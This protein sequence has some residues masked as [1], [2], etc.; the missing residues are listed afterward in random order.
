M[1]SL[2]AGLMVTVLAVSTG[3]N[4][5]TPGGPGATERSANKPMVERADDT[6]ILDVPMTSTKL[7]QGETKELA[8]SVARGGNFDEEV[9]LKFAGVP[10]GVTLN[11][12]SPVIRHGEKDTKIT[13]A[14]AD[15]A[16]LGDFTLKVT[17]KPTKAPTPQTSSRLLSRKSSGYGARRKT[18]I[19]A[20]HALSSLS[21]CPQAIAGTEGFTCLSFPGASPHRGS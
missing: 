17:G 18:Q 4:Q 15:T 8:I 2:F 12:A 1:K 9:T 3:C 16:S 11:P 6:F 13:L 10:K 5:G 19:P 14:A 20:S 7:K 21:S